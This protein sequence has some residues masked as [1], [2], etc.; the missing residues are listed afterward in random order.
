MADRSSQRIVAPLAWSV[1]SLSVALATLGLFFLY[2]NGSFAP[3]L[4]DSLG[5]DAVAAVAF[6]TVGAIIASRRPGNPIGWIFCLVG[7]SLGIATFAAQYAVY[8][9]V[10][11]PGALPAGVLAAWIGTWAW[12]PGIIL[13]TT[14]LLLLFPH[15]RLPSRRWRPVAWISTGATALGVAV[16]MVLPW[17]LLIPGLPAENPFEVGVA[18]T[19]EVAIFVA[20]VGVGMTTMTLSVLALVLRFSR[21]RGVERQQLK[22]FVYAGSLTVVLFFFPLVPALSV[23]GSFLQVVAAPL[24]PAA[25]GVAILRH[26]LYDVDVLINRTLVYGGLTAT[27]ALVYFGSVVGSQYLLRTLAGQ[28]SQLAVVASTLLIAALF[29]PLRRRLQD[30]I[31]RLFYRNKYDAKETLEAFAARLREET[32]LGT[33]SKDLIMVVEETVRPVHTSLWLREP[34]RDPGEASP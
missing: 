26:R 10:T 14:F 17:G 25:A 33:L 12:V 31:D 6:P 30:F 9:L 24:L 22:W 3:F 21:S 11:E 8:A 4:E 5:V 34:A 15:G 23:L 16:V 32:D 1:W 29:N 13:G 27:L 18:R 2:L 7:L 28:E 19:V 20:W